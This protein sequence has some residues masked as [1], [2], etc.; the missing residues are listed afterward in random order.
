M[1]RFEPGEYDIGLFTERHKTRIGW[2]VLHRHLTLKIWEDQTTQK[3]MFELVGTL[4]SC[5]K[6]NRCSG[7]LQFL[8][9][10]DNQEIKVIND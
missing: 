3:P 2:K 6:E 5:C 10:P 7:A 4:E 8:W 1:T 9:Y